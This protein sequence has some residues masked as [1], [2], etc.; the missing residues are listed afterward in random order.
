MRF[1]RSP[2]GAVTAPRSQ[3]SSGPDV[4]AIIAT[5]VVGGACA[6]QVTAPTLPASVTRVVLSPQ[7]GV[8]LRGST[9]QLAVT[10]F[11]SVGDTVRGGTVTWGSHDTTVA[12]VSGLGV[13]LG[14]ALGS[15]I[16]TA[17]VDADT[18]GAI[19]DVVAPVASISITPSDLMFAAGPLALE[20]ILLDAAGDTLT[21][22][23]VV[24][25]S[26]DTSIAVV[27]ATGA[28]LGRRS[29]PVV[30]QARSEGKVARA[31]FAI[32][33]PRFVVV[34][35]GNFT[36]CAVA[37]DSVPYCWG[38]G[39]S[40]GNGQPYGGYA[41]NVKPAAN[42]PMGV[43]GGLRLTTVT[44]GF[45]FN[46]SLTGAGTAYCWG[47]GLA[48]TLG[49]GG[50][51]HSNTPVPVTGGLTFSAISSDG[52]HT[53]AIAADSTAVCWGEGGTGA[54]GN[55]S[56]SNTAVPTP[57]AGQM[58][59]IAVT[60]G[61]YHSCA[62]APD[63]TAYCWGM[64]S[65]GQLGDSSTPAPNTN[66]LQPTPVPVSGGLRFRVIEAGGL[67]TCGIAT[68]GMAYC[69]GGNAQGQLGNSGTGPCAFNIPCSPFPVRVSGGLTFVA[70]SAGREQT[71]AVRSDGSGYC[72]GDGTDGVLGNG[73]TLA[74][75]SPTAVAGGLSFAAISSGDF[76]TCGLT[77][78][79]IAYC[80]G[81]NFLQQLGGGVPGDA[82]TPI[83]VIGQP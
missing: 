1:F 17:S 79:Q 82:W 83:R 15:T 52:S 18:A 69:W 14:R 55:G 72:W 80:W 61:Y 28:L 3:Y 42:F 16:V 30:I 62:L 76:H 68:D 43:V 65:Y 66:T 9:L 71:C 57:V 7:R 22:R 34:D 6:E 4:L 53:C 70:I 35:A 74:R 46:C 48:G 49:N 73:D 12:T 39:V 41:P 51:N 45:Q 13:V 64:H 60:S 36:S 40:L 50:T 2:A 11:D 58:K 56:L 67:H 29:G 78:A 77:A 75:P 33:T 44:G 21:N 25:T 54:L 27:L 81:S 32:R 24:W 31:D 23:P 26:S 10:L 38:S 59:F 47:A 8:I 63:S 19:I 5:A 37:T 20:P